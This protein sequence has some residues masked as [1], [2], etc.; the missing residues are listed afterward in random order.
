MPKI[1]DLI[2]RL[3]GEPRRCAPALDGAAR[4]ELEGGVV[5]LSFS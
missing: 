1:R 4:R 5:E 2:A 3:R